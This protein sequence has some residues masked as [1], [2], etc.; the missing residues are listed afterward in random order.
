MVQYLRMHPDKPFVASS[1]RQYS[2]HEL[3]DEIELKTQ[4]GIENLSALL[5]LTIDR[6]S[7][8]KDKL[9][10]KEEEQ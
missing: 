6:V 4:D 9:S 5:Q 10:P 8:G 1:K 7:R 3:A 2:Y